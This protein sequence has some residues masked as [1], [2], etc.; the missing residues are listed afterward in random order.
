MSDGLFISYINNS[1]DYEEQKYLVGSNMKLS[2]RN[3]LMFQR[4][5][6]YP[7]DPEFESLVIT[8]MIFLC[9]YVK[10][11]LYEIVSGTQTQLTL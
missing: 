8:S 1:S 6:L 5:L 2:C 9:A 4:H 3:I 7:V 11:I 10:H